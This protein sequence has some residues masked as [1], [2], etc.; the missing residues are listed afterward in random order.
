[1]S[2]GELVVRPLG[3]LLLVRPEDQEYTTPGGLI[4]LDTSDPD[5]S[6]GE[7]VAAGDGCRELAVGDRVVWSTFAASDLTGE[8]GT[9][10]VFEDDVLAKYL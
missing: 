9:L 2:R 10:L 4:L 3:R 7:V 1:V 6:R 5:V 8:E